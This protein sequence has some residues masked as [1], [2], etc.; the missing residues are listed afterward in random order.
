MIVLLL[1]FFSFDLSVLG[2][3]ALVAQS[4][5]VESVVTAVPWLLVS[6]SAVIAA[7]TKASSVMFS[8]RMAADI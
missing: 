3:V 4:E 6:A 7:A 2:S 5:C 1:G 8:L